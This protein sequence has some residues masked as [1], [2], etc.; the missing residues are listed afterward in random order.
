MR[1]FFIITMALCVL[2][3]G[4][5]QD[6]NEKNDVISEAETMQESTEYKKAAISDVSK[7]KIIDATSG[8]YAEDL[9][10][11]ISNDYILR[12]QSVYD[13]VTAT[14]EI[15]M[16]EPLY[17]IELI[18]TD[19]SIADVWTIDEYRTIK[20]KDGMLILRE[21]EVDKLLTD[22]EE[23]YSLGYNLLARQ[24]G[25]GYF[26]VLTKVN[27]A[28]FRKFSRINMDTP[29]EYSLSVELIDGLKQNWQDIDVSSIPVS[30]YKIL[31]TINF[32]NSDGNGLQTWHIAENN[33]IYTSYGYELSGDFIVKWVDKVISEAN[34]Q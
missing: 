24:P 33:R 32:Y 16:R 19:G 31:Y 10:I 17:S 23:E 21:G 28:E 1:R 9:H 18:N 8:N 22:I 25:G 26:S 29:V 27:N 11:D 7:L 3:T 13:N 30:D 5:G 15:S 6:Y 14:D 34:I 20:T 4:C 2:L 12:F